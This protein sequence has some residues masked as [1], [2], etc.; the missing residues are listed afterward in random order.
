[1]RKLTA[2]VSRAPIVPFEAYH[3]EE[4]MP[5]L[6]PTEFTVGTRSSFYISSLLGGNS[7]NRS[8]NYHAQI[9]VIY[10]RL[11]VTA[12]SPIGDITISPVITRLISDVALSYAVFGSG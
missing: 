11:R 2:S 9:R 3:L 10:Y 5:P 1:M 8:A 7:A 6:Q 12:H 4:G